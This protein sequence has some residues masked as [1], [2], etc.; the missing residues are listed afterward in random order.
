MKDTGS[1]VAWNASDSSSDFQGVLRFAGGLLEHDGE[2]RLDPTLPPDEVGRGVVGLQALELTAVGSKLELREV[3]GSEEVRKIRW[4][5]GQRAS[6]RGF[7]LHPLGAERWNISVRKFAYC[8]AERP[9]PFRRKL[10]RPLTQPIKELAAA[11]V[12]NVLL[13][14]S[15]LLKVAPHHYKGVHERGPDTE[16]TDLLLQF[17]RRITQRASFDA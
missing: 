2:A 1:L 4:R 7:E 5:E 15:T 17:D 8:V 6:R 13:V 14:P 3:L 12:C 9:Q 11:H 16:T 10:G